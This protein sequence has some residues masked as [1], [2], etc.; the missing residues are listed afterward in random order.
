MTDEQ[1]KEKVNTDYQNSMLKWILGGVAA[2]IVGIGFFA[3]VAF[4]TFMTRDEAQQNFL[5][6][7]MKTA[8][9]KMTSVLEKSDDRTDTLVKAVENNTRAVEGLRDDTRAGVWRAVE[10]PAA[11]PP[12]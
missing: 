10:A 7:D 1:D 8:I 9:E 11:L 4:N 5:R 6:Q 12:K 2:G 3:Q